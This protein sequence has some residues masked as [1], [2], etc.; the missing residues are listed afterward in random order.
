AAGGEHVV[1]PARPFAADGTRLD[2]AVELP[3]EG[4]LEA[5]TVAHHLEG[6]PVYGLIRIAGAT[7]PLFHLLSE[8]VEPGV[9]VR[10]VWREERTGSILDIA[11]FAPA[12]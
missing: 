3:D 1:V 9:R 6:A 8:V 7:T 12:G 2:E 4:T 11:H 10:A 5:V